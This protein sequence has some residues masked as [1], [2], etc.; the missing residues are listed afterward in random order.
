MKQSGKADE[1]KINEMK[2]RGKIRCHQLHLITCRENGILIVGSRSIL[3]FM[4]SLIR[5]AG[6]DGDVNPAGDD[7][8]I[9][10]SFIIFMNILT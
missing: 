10:L 3:T 8:S 5:L 2:I 7:V 9:S 4:L 6:V 1:K